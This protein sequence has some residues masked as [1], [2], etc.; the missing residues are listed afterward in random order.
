MSNSYFNDF[1]ATKPTFGG[2]DVSGE[3]PQLEGKTVRS[4]NTGDKVFLIKD[5][6]KHWVMNL[7]VLTALGLK[8][9]EELFVESLSSY[10]SGEPIKMDNIQH[11]KASPETSVIANQEAETLATAPNDSEVEREVVV[12][13]AH[14][15]E[16]VPHVVK[17][18]LTS[19]IIPALLN[20]YQ[21]L[22]L[23]G[24]CIG[25]INEHTIRLKTPYE[26]ILVLNGGI[27]INPQYSH[28]DKVIAN[29][30]N[31]GYAKA[32]NQGIRVSQGDS[33][34]LMNNDVKVYEHWLEDLLEGLRH[35]DLVAATPMY[36]REDP[37]LRGKESQ[38]IRRQFMELPI[39]NSFS[40]FED[41][42][43]VAVK[44]SVFE[45]IGLFDEQ[46]EFTCEDIDF[47]RRMKDAGLSYASFKRVPVHHVGGA[48]ST[49]EKD[50]QMNQAK[51]KYKEKWKESQ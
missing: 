43:C 41:F 23:T 11:F 32:V 30:E 13:P 51:A 15:D 34:V 19:I 12:T 18:G 24:D 47:K 40:D 27:E 16:G 33:I 45:T 21:M 42:S 39:Q 35:K 6:R 8:L 48:T 29:K 20:S 7:E 1:G 5:G 44:R 10:I 26:I 36:H 28:A 17:E 4:K 46:F 14:K 25:Q 3:T 38:K 9:G 22:H 49:P 37:W 31:L 2:N 50:E